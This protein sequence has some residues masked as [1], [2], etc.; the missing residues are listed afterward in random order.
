M[1]INSIFRKFITKQEESPAGKT[2]E[3]KKI[4]NQKSPI[5]DISIHFEKIQQDL[6]KKI[7]EIVDSKT[8]VYKAK[9]EEVKN[10]ES[11]VAKMEQMASF[12]KKGVDELKERLDKIDEIVLD[13]S[14]LYEVV[15]STVNPFVGD[16][17]SPLN[18]KFIEFEK[19]L[20]ELNKKALSSNISEDINE[21]FLTFEK[22]IHD[23]KKI[24][25]SN[26]EKEQ[27]QIQKIAEIVTERIKP[28][29]EF[30]VQAIPAND[31]TAA[32]IPSKPQ[33]YPLLESDK[34]EIKLT[35]LDNSP[36]T[37][38]IILYWL[39]FLME[40]VGRNNV[41]DVLEYYVEIGWIN[42]DVCSKIM[43]YTKGIDYFVEKPTWKLLPDDHTKSLLLIEQLSGR[44]V[45]KSSFAKI[46]RDINKIVK[47]SNS[48]VS[49][50]NIE[51]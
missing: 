1:S 9:A 37:S 15:S 27:A 11:K 8:Q 48:M 41:V 30:R 12:D 14:S 44:K 24:T 33:E 2:F 35:Q 36:E 43:D 51:L 28:E 40:K 25:E 49:S 3:V 20:T 42:D 39:K 46:E 45:D 34:H 5:T 23:L 31:R 50:N 13:L 17:Q 21:K 26:P 29:L 22:S 18:E 10:L 6:T 32:E 4:P 16:A 7:E 47:Y 19:N 38:I